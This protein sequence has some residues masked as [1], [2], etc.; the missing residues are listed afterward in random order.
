MWKNI[1]QNSKRYISYCLVALGL[2]CF[3]IDLIQANPHEL[4]CSF[5][6][7]IADTVLDDV[8]EPIPGVS[9]L[10]VGTSSGT[11]TDLDGRFE[12]TVP[13]EGGSL[14]FSFIGFII[15]RIEISNQSEINITLNQN[16]SFQERILLYG[17]KDGK[18]G[19][20]AKRR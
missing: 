2:I 9:V 5:D 13:A 20:W 15:Q 16:L 10:L 4:V 12:I 19:M 7:T 14:Q 18:A 1:Y 8:G 17:E 6:R 3:K 11:D